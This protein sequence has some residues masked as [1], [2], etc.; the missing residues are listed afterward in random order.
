MFEKEHSA[1]DS[2][3]SIT[4]KIGQTRDKNLSFGVTPRPLL[5]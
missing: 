4:E 5:T 3:L 1:Q 2:I